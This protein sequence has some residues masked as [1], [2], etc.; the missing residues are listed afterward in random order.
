MAY[1]LWVAAGIA[2][3]FAARRWQGNVANLDAREN[4]GVFLLAVGG[5][6]LGAYLF[7]LP[8]SL[9]AWTAPPPDGARGPDGLLLGGRTV[10]GG[11]LGGWIA[12][13]AGKRAFGIAK[14][15]GDAFALPLAIALGFGRLGCASAGC[16]AGSAC[17]A[18]PFT[19]VGAGGAP[20][21]PVAQLEAVYHFVAA[22][23]LAWATRRG[24]IPGRRLAAYLTVYALVRLGLEG[25]RTNPA[26]L[27]GLTYYQMLAL[28]LFALAGATWWLRSRAPRR[29]T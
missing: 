19:V 28:A 5:A 24:W 23:M 29:D 12:V 15:T 16:C 18:G 11:L 20:H 1:F 10:L 7:Q 17:M 25:W 4:T 8:A 6:I 26:V 27:A 3:A 2:C 22:G 13:E 14:P 9:L 21:L